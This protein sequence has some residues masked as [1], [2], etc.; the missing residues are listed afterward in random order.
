MAKDVQRFEKKRE[1]ALLMIKAFHLSFADQHPPQ[2]QV[3]FLS[4]YFMNF[5]NVKFRYFQFKTPFVGRTRNKPRFMNNFCTRFLFLAKNI[6]FR[7]FILCSY[8]CSKKIELEKNYL[9]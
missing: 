7:K 6:L 9:N 5:F 2:C 3:N 8:L 4:H 1:V